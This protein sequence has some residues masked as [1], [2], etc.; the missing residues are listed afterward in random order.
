MIPARLVR[1][2]RWIITML[3]LLIAVM[4]IIGAGW[5]DASLPYG[6]IWPT[7][8][9]E[10]SFKEQFILF[11]IRLPRMVI[12]LLAGMALALS[13]AILQQL[14]R[15]DLADP[16]ILGI[17]SGAGVA[18]TVLFLFIPLE[19]GTHAFAI[20]LAAF[21]G[22]LAVSGIIYGLAY[23]RNRG[24]QPM[25]LVLIGIGCS[26]AL[27][28]AMI[29]MIS[30]A[31]RRDVD[32]IA[33]WLAGNLWGD[34]WPFILAL[35]PWLVCLIPYAFWKS[36]P[37]DLLAL[38]EATARSV[39]VSVERERFRLLIAS[40]ALA[41]SAVSVAGSISFIGLMA[42]HMAKRLVGPRSRLHFPIAA[43]IGGFLLLAAGTVGKQLTEPDGIPAGVMAALIGAPYFIYL[44]LKK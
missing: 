36:K 24:L 11:S 2:Q 12:C 32:F 39:G 4:L 42:P 6:R 16:G 14:T 31:D 22:A 33:Q 28:G 7:L 10:G 38:G 43:L 26:L 3:L 18:V 37:L 35:L 9:G 21:V 17:H 34:D 15:N 5:G 27:S 40:V 13:G 1:K 29:M 23:E 25:K 30:T 19:T 44:L 20:P 8:M 41:A